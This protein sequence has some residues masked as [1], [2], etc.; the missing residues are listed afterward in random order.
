MLK[1]VKLEGSEQAGAEQVI[2]AS[3]PELVTLPSD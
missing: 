2:S 3:Q 1:A